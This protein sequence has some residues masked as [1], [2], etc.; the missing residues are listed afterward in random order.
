MKHNR[1][2]LLQ[3]LI[4]SAFFF[5]EAPIC[6]AN[7][8]L[9]FDVNLDTSGL[10]GHP[11]GPF[12]IDFQLNDGSGNFA[13]VNTA[14][15]SNFMFG[16]GSPSGTAHLFG[17]AKGSLSTGVTLTDSSAFINEFF[18]P[19]TPGS[20]L[21]FT[22][23]LTTNVDPGLT[24]DAFSFSILDN[25]LAPIPTTNF[26]DAFLFVNINSADL[27][28]A[29]VRTFAGDPTRPPLAGGDVI[30]IGAPQIPGV[31]ETGSSISMLLI[32]LGAVWCFT[33]PLFSRVCA[34]AESWKA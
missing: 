6:R 22:V 2:H 16:G 8:V 32:G 25:L 9:V 33:A 11:A 12:S 20:F 17:G 15:I 1:Y 4:I 7:L 27:T 14:T 21:S 24:P 5:L 13:G 10:I 26:A 34:L 19:F 23:S 3:G 29:D 18:E 28:K 30:R 31:P